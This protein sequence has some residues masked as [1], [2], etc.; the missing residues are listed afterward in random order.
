ML[1]DP[2]HRQT[3]RWSD[4][5]DSFIVV[6]TN[7]FTRNIL[8]NHFKHSNFASFVRQLNK[9]DF[10]KIRSNEESGGNSYGHQT[11][12][13]KHPDF[14]LNNIDNLDNIKRKAPAPRKQVQQSEDGGVQQIEELNSQVQDL[15]KVNQEMTNQVQR[16]ASD[17]H[18]VI[19][20]LNTMQHV[21]QQ[22]EERVRVQEK[23][24]NN[25][26]VYLQKLDDEIKEMRPV[27]G[28]PSQQLHDNEGRP[29]APVSPEN[30]VT[31]PAAS[32][33]GSREHLSTPL[34]RAQM[35]LDNHPDI[36]DANP[37]MGRF[38]GLSQ[39]GPS[40]YNEFGAVNRLSQ[41]GQR[42][43]ALSNGVSTIPEDGGATFAIG[44]GTTMVEPFSN[45]NL[46]YS[47]QPPQHENA[48]LG[49]RGRPAPSR[50]RSTPFVPPN[51]Q[52]PP[53]VLL[54]EDDPTCARIGS[55]FLQTAECSVDMASNGLIAVN[56]L[57]SGKYDLVLMDIVMPQLDGVSA[58]SLVRQFDSTTPIIAMTSNIRR[59]D[60]NMYFNH[61]MNDVLPKPFTKEGLLNMLEK[62]L[63]HLKA[64]EGQIPTQLN[65]NE[66]DNRIIVE[67]GNI[68]AKSGLK[69]SQSPSKS[70]QNAVLYGRPPSDAVEDPIGETPSV[71]E[72]TAY[73]NLI[74]GYLGDSTAPRTT[75]TFPS[76]GALAHGIRRGASEMDGSQQQ[77]MGLDAKKT[78]Y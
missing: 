50:K 12:E 31:G 8:P 68:M 44:P 77:L 39:S 3:V 4:A 43:A 78:R 36:L 21:L 46:G 64:N 61:G 5:G 74:P 11:W 33:P 17:N 51:W 30:S 37:T 63:S 35:L 15:S 60:I 25:I 70:P 52:T 38:R 27:G 54:V 22:H 75:G 18:A 72:D 45:G 65:F 56:K 19:Q 71:V 13:F 10:H 41:N 23:V 2:T 42:Q 59:D 29:S 57:N 26:M 76:P 7:E 66:H 6:D 69:Y 32:A 73:A 55:K 9:Y 53:R 62:Y 34:Q 28:I 67:Q 47:I 14:Q 58:A 49:I 24:I 40:D 16:L 20:E 1:E 48:N